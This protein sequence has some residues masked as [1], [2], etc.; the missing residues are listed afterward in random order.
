MLDVDER[1]FMS[2]TV[3]TRFSRGI[4]IRVS[5]SSG[6]APGRVVAMALYGMFISGWISRGIVDKE[7][8]PIT[9]LMSKNSHV[10]AGRS[11]KNPEIPGDF[12]EILFIVCGYSFSLFQE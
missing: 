3:A 7:K 10:M 12:S 5:M 11:I 8:A 2:D 4:V 1:E 6:L 9:I